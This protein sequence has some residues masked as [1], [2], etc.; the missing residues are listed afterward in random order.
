MPVYHV[1]DI[2]RIVNGRQY[3]ESDLRIDHIL[4]DSRKI[5]FPSGSVFFAIPGFRR[6]GHLFIPESYQRGVRC[7]IVS[8]L[9]VTE[10]FPGAVFIV[11]EN[12][13]DA[14]QTLVA[15]HRS[16]FHYP[17]IGI[18]GSNGKTIVKE[19][20]N[21]LLQGRFRIIRSPKSYN[22]QIGVPLSVWL[23]KADAE[24]GIFEAGIS[25]VGEM[26]KLARI[27]RPDIGVFTNI[28]DA[29]SEGFASVREK[30]REKLF[31]F[32][33]SR[34]I[35]YCRD[36]REL[37]EE[38]RSFA[39]IRPTRLFCWSS[40]PGA[41]V[42]VVNVA[43]QVDKSVINLRYLSE[44]II[45]TI[46][47]SGRAAVENSITCAMVMMERG[48]TA[49]QVVE[50]MKG[51]PSLA[52]RLEMKQGINRCTIINDSYS[53]DLSSLKLALDFLGQQQQGNG[54][55]ILSDIP[56]SG[57][58]EEERYLHIAN[59]LKRSRIS[60]MVGIGP[61][62]CKYITLFTAA[63]LKAEVFIST[64]D[65]IQQFHPFQYRDEVVL[66]KGA[67]VFEFER[68]NQLL[69]VKLHQTVLSVNLSAISH[70]LSEYR[71]FLS[72]Q[73]KL[74]VMVK[75]F[76]Y[77][78][79]S[80]EIANLMQYHK[81]DYL[82]VAY[83]DEGTELRKAGISTPIMVMNPEEASF[84]A[85]TGFDLQPEIFSFHLLKQFGAYLR[86][87]GITE[88]P[89]HLKL[90][91]GMHRLGFEP[92][93]LQSVVSQLK[94]NNLFRVISVFT[95]LAGSEDPAEDDFTRQQAAQFT[96]AAA[97]LSGQLGY[98][99]IRHISNTAAIH[100][101]PQWQMDMVRLGIGLYGSG[102]G[103]GNLH[104]QEASS[105]TTTIAQIRVVKSGESVGY[106]RMGVLQR[107]SR[108]ATIRIGYADGY[109][110]SLSNGIGKVMIRNKAV[111][112]VG[113]VCMDMTMVDVT[114]IPGLQE[115]E[116][117]LI[118]GKGLS[119]NDLANW[120][121]TIPYDIM[122]GISQRVKRVYFE[123]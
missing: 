17:V 40:Q 55:V 54:V 84:P 116:E 64:G 113:L 8:Q 35:I 46:P 94:D 58:P 16:G 14:L 50:G 41:E 4:T 120:A 65:F 92:S 1:R 104:L 86:S 32:S 101:H 24:L 97:Y 15:Y 37:D 21:H 60:R 63:G 61:L 18:T 30:I 39:S 115:G 103:K 118:F 90:D 10:D 67:R 82:A 69:E 87:E 34:V 47:F 96:A 31:L 114:D 29:H 112:V 121:G 56:E 80:Y 12:P 42:Q 117:V 79:G 77:G 51:L 25:T 108:I 88:Y 85:I 11:V 100:R 110:R 99:F 23:M 122:T 48:M 71:K 111:P 75:A 74:M 38:V 5:L 119:V 107:D 62:M 13:L 45:Y 73:T 53:A 106:N 26:E 20:L 3:G 6:D 7:F 123:E 33:E 52:M 19:W 70:N 91:T 22:S 36:Y 89:I 105:L 83:T 44:D 49:Q 76:S 59:I 43:S 102:A 57:I 2:A 28:G 95:H 81:V 93:D 109:P 68:I 98:S 27:I 78:S 66:L 9:P 72:P